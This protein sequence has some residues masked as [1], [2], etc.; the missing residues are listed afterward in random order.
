MR[1]PSSETILRS[2]R[3]CRRPGVA[4]RMCASREALACDPIEIPQQ[5]FDLTKAVPDIFDDQGICAPIDLDFSANAQIAFDN[6]D[7]L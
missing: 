1:T 2:T 5:S 6:V 4:T 3:S 7:R